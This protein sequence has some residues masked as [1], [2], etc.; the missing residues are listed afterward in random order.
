MLV[1]YPE[2]FG[3]EVLEWSLGHMNMSISHVCDHPRDESLGHIREGWGGQLDEI[4]EGECV[5]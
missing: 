1:P 4:T 3:I 2:N 5:D